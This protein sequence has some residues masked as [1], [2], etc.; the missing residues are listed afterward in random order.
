[1]LYRGKLPEV[2]F[3]NIRILAF[4]KDDTITPPNKPMELSMAEE[5]KRLTYNRYI[6]ILTARDIHTCREQIL[7]AMEQVNERK[8]RLI[9]ACCNG[10]QIYAF[11]N[12]KQE[13]LLKSSLEGELESPEFFDEIG[14]KLAEELGAPDLYFERRSDTMGTFVCISRDS[15]D[16][17]RKNF[18]PDGERRSA[19]IKKFRHLFPNEYEVIP[20]GKTSIDVSLYNKEAGM[21]HL[22][23]YFQYP[24]YGDVVFFGDGFDGGNDTPVENIPSVLS[25]KV[26]NYQQTLDLLKQIP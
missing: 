6:L 17:Q 7:N 4:D 18:D 25:V 21:R 22:L 5:L 1:M 24:L 10:S 12:K 26:E 16:E 19:A 23:E 9:L 14:K 2:D 8:N 20:G 3:N 15:T 11:D 13:Y